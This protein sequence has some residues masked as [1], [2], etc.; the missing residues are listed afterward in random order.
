MTERNGMTL[1][2]YTREVDVPDG[3]TDKMVE[4]FAVIGNYQETLPNPVPRPAPGEEDD[5][6]PQIPN[7]QNKADFCMSEVRDWMFQK[8]EQAALQVIHTASRESQTEVR[9]AADIAKESII[10]VELK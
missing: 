3:F 5:W 6:E 10:T 4:A 2:G 7:P 9:R 8:V 1:N